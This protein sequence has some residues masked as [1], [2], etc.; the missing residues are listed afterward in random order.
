MKLSC[1]HMH[2]KEFQIFFIHLLEN[3]W[4]LNFNPFQHSVS[5]LLYSFIYL[6]CFSIALTNPQTKCGFEVLQSNFILFCVWNLK[7]STF[8]VFLYAFYQ[9]KKVFTSSQFAKSCVMNGNIFLSNKFPSSV[10]I[11]KL[12]FQFAYVEAI[13]YYYMI[14]FSFESSLYWIISFRGNNENNKQL[15]KQ[16]HWR[17]RMDT[18]HKEVKLCFQLSSIYYIICTQTVIRLFKKILLFNFS[19]FLKL[20][21]NWRIITW[22]SCVGFCYTTTRISHRQTYALLVKP[23]SH[24]PIHSTPLVVPEHRVWTTSYSKFPLSILHFAMYKLP[25]LLYHSLF[26]HFDLSSTRLWLHLVL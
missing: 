11:M 12:F 26:I 4:L 1:T 18:V 24:L 8:Q 2:T 22:Q 21:F 3:T 13:D 19:Y 15:A 10:M 23:H 6:F 7:F 14:Y 20:I 17:I 5:S 16:R 9:I 25:M